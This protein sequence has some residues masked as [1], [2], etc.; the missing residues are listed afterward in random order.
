V[1]LLWSIASL[2]LLT[3]MSALCSGLETGLYA[4]DRVRLQIRA[5]EGDRRARRLLAAAARPATTVAA[6]LVANNIV[7]YFVSVSA[8]SAL[9][10]VLPVSQDV[11]RR[12]VDTAVI[13]P[14]L[15]VFG[16]LGPKDA[17]LRRPTLL[18][19][20]YEPALTFVRSLGALVATPLLALAER[21]G[22]GRGGAHEA[23][24]FDRAAIGRLLSEEA[25]I[26]GLSPAQRRLATRVLQLR[27]A[28]VE[29]RMTPVSKVA[30]VSTDASAAEVV[31]VGVQARKSRL[32]VRAP[33]AAA[34]AGYVSVTDA[35]VVA[36][37]D[38]EHAP[39]FAEARL[40]G[41]PRV[42]A[43]TEVGKALVGFQRRRKPIMQVV[44]ADGR[45]TG[46][47]AASDLVDAL[48]EI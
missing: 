29:E 7:N 11:V 18:M 24:R 23:S 14:I 19:R 47:L 22:G 26:A 21:F 3:A 40:H 37:E 25:E 9:D 43:R 42:L 15:F 41:L 6:L 44:D 16:D 35:A 32:P 33:G 48:F 38:D 27:Q 10:H 4:V 31:R 39:G 34:Y 46:L 5:E 17:F 20:R 1:I 28:R 12:L 8:S 30:E 2:A 13:T 36:G 45:A